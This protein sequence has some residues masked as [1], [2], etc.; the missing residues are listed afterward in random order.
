MKFRPSRILISSTKIFGPT[1]C[2]VHAV[3]QGFILGE[4]ATRSIRGMRELG[5]VDEV[6]HRWT[7]T[8]STSSNSTT[9]GVPVRHV[10]V[11]LAVVAVA[12]SH[13]RTKIFSC[14]KFGLFDFY[15]K[16][17]LLQRVTCSKSLHNRIHKFHFFFFYCYETFIRAIS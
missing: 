15:D 17:L 11:S 2:I 7:S 14:Q 13:T 9:R 16:F 4:E 1:Y 10:K 12:L 6:V 3:V 5:A 8:T